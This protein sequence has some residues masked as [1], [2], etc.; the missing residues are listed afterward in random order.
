M[1]ILAI[2]LGSYSVKFLEIFAEKN[3]FDL[4]S[5][6][7][8]PLVDTDQSSED[9]SLPTR[10]LQTIKGHLEQREFKGQLIFQLPNEY[11]TSRYLK[12][13]VTQ[14]KKVEQ[15]IPFQLDESI[16]FSLSQTHYAAV[17]KKKESST[18]AVISASEL[19][20]FENFFNLM[21]SIEIMPDIL[22]S[23][24]SAICNIASPGILDHPC[25]VLD[26]GHN[27]TKGYF[28]ANNE[29]VSNHISYIAGRS[30]DEVIS[31]TYQIS[32]QEAVRYKHENCFF[33]TENEYD[34]VNQEQMDFARLM[35]QVFSPLLQEY[36]RWNMG[37]SIKNK[38][39]IKGIYITG[40]S[41]NIKN[42]IPFLIQE[43][44][45]EVHHLDVYMGLRPSQGVRPFNQNEKNSFTLCYMMASSKSSDITTAN[46]LKG[47][48]SNKSSEKIPLHSLSFVGA[49]VLTLFLFVILILG[50]EKT[51]LTGQEKKLDKKIT[52][53]IKG[54]SLEI[55]RKIQKRYKRKPSKILDF[56]KKKNN[57]S[58]KEI[59]KLVSL[60]K[61]NALSPL[62]TLSKNLMANKNV[63][64]VRFSNIKKNVKA[65]FNS[66]HPKE[67]SQMAKP[68]KNCSIK[69]Y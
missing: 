36:Q 18:I 43:L 17:L 63:N 46:F 11:I 66:N 29:V 41:S 60:D 20:S 22:T 49:R 54:P 58:K 45:T 32:E 55:P 53:L 19:A 21:D 51:L 24:L 50:V 10:Q 62:I 39:K 30:I 35:K 69:K 15:T 13:P 33:L 28:I 68:V 47:E 6:N 67:L 65:V 4:I 31:N 34:S 12:I 38:E 23:E 37:F 27:T 26:I 59:E 25:A 14:R 3:S 52:K 7:E 2:D 8:L 56:L 9:S 44:S 5:F 61:T 64:L 48:Y 42:I 1:N 57:F 16:P 40:G